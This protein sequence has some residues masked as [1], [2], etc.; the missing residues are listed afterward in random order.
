M[1]GML[2]LIA[3]QGLLPRTLVNALGTPPLVCALQ[4]FE[5]DEVTPDIVF[6]LETLGSFLTDLTSRGVTDVCFAGGIRRPV[7]DPTAIDAATIP[8]VP[9]LQ[10]ALQSGDDSAL[11]AVIGLFEAQNLH[12]TAAHEIVPAL[13]PQTG[14]LTRAQPGEQHERDAARGGDV[15]RAMAVADI[16]QA[17]VIANGQALAVEGTFGTDWMLSSLQNRP[18][19]P[20]GGLLYKAPKPGQDRRADLPVIGQS[21]IDGVARAGL[22]GLVIEQGGVM[23]LERDA[24]VR[25]C[26]A[27][28]LFLWV[29]D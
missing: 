14:V 10:K 3:G 20:K 19:H 6:R 7:I 12:V 16:G 28:G 24:V 9:V 18:P 23:V 21:T 1:S 26:D 13:L 29:R 15:V 25:A 2:A 11:R 22:S 4:G 8:L 27:A 17:C 5:P